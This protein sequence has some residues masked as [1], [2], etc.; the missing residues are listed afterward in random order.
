MLKPRLARVLRHLA[1]RLLSTWPERLRQR[2]RL[3]ELTD[4]QLRDV[5]LTRADVRRE[6]E[7]P[8]W[9]A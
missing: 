9:R 1:K 3:A 2:D 4:A 7:K 8:F 5:G 6:T